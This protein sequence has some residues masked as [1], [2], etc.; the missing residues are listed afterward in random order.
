MSVGKGRHEMPFYADSVSDISIGNDFLWLTKTITIIDGLLQ[1]A[2]R[3]SARG[4]TAERLRTSV[5]QTSGARER[6]L[7]EP[8]DLHRAARERMLRGT[9]AAVKLRPI[10]KNICSAASLS[11]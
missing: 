2:R 11:L 5:L 10:K 4:L 9:R 3:S 8:A 1:T 7:R 6:L